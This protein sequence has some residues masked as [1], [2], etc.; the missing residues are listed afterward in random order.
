M[1]ADAKPV[2]ARGPR[3]VIRRA[4]ALAL[5]LVCAGCEPYDSNEVFDY[6]CKSR[7]VTYDETVYLRAVV[8]RYIQNNIESSKFNEKYA[9]FITLIN[10]KGEEISIEKFKDVNFR[11]AAADLFL[12]TYPDCCQVGRS[13][14]NDYGYDIKKHY[15]VRQQRRDGQLAA[16]VTIKSTYITKEKDGSIRRIPIDHNFEVGN[17]LEIR[18]AIWDRAEFLLWPYQ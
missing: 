16:F 17:C 6:R 5:V 1:R 4:A 18:D 2:E 7:G 9:T 3:S 10:K 11:Y 13:P 12:L 8:G 15:Y 14:V